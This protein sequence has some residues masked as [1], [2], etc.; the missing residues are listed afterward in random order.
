MAI[1]FERF[2]LKDFRLLTGSLEIAGGLGQVGG[3]WFPQLGFLSSLGLAL[4]MVCGVWARWRIRD[5]FLAFIPAVALG[6]NNLIL[7]WL[8]WKI[9]N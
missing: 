6:L 7:V 3:F 9:F 1:E 2:K 4:L 8:N 5:P